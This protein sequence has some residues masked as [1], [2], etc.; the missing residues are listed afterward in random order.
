MSETIPTEVSQI[1]KR[2]QGTKIVDTFIP[3]KQPFKS[4]IKLMAKPWITP[5]IKK[6]I[7]IKNDL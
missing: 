1:S 4:E 3:L 5:A 6:S 2:T 7:T